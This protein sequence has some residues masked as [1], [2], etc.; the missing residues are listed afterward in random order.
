MINNKKIL[1]TGGTGS[2]GKNLI[3]HLEKKFNPKKIIIFSR[4][5]LKQSQMMTEFSKIRSKLRFFIGDVR[6][7]SRLNLAMRDVDIVFHAAAL[8]NVPLAE[9]NPFEAI[10]TNI[11]GAQNVIDAS[12]ENNVKNV[13]ALSTDKASSPI[14][15]YGATKLAS[16]KLFI[17]ANNFKGKNKTKFS[18]V[19]Y[20]N[21]MG[22]RGSVVPIFNQFRD[23]NYIPITDKRMTRFNITLQEAINFVLNSLKIMQGGE[24]FVPKIPSFK[25]TDL[26]KAMYPKKKVKIIGLRPG[27]KI[28]EEMV[29]TG[30]SINT[31]RYKNSYIICPQSEFFKWDKKKHLRSKKGSKKFPENTSYNSGSNNEFLTVE[32]IRLILKANKFI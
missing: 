17:T 4:D 27:E 1:V 10:K 15:L 11:F 16:D 30:E 23:K 18:V 8:K 2:F 28:H 22:S 21:V 32:A 5:E 26:A 25:I 19:R 31:I 12:F 14:N 9:Y 3:S 7:Y 24:I 20:G 13:L 6:D 29:S